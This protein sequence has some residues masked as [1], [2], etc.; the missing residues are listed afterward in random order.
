MLLAHHPHERRHRDFKPGQPLSIAQIIALHSVD[1]ETVALVWMMLE[2]GAS[3]TVAGFTEP[4]PG[5]GKSTTLHALL[6]FLPER[7]ALAIMSGRYETFAF[8]R[9]PGVDPATTYAVCSEISDHQSTYMWGASARRYLLLPAQGYHVMTSVHADTLDDVLHLY[10]H[11][12]LLRIEDIRRL[13][14]VVNIGSTGGGDS[15]RRRWLTTCF[16]Q[17]QPDPLHPETLVPFVLSRWDGSDDSFQHADQLVLDELADWTQLTREDFMAALTRRA[18]CLR[19]LAR[20]QGADL[21]HVQAAISEVRGR[22]SK[23]RFS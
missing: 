8:T 19:E 20:G 6:A 10:Q 11:D 3:L 15:Q 13:G 9:L 21:H 2:H 18:A 7:S 1:V 16:L 23:P 22:D 17:P 14:L 5:A 4:R 12:L